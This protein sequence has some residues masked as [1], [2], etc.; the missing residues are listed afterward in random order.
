MTYINKVLDMLSIS[1]K[2]ILTGQITYRWKLLDSREA[3]GSSI[4]IA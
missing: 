4:H 1:T 2:I 3:T